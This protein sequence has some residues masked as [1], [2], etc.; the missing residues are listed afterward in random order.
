[1]WGVVAAGWAFRGPWA[2]VCPVAAEEGYVEQPVRSRGP[3]AA[4]AQAGST[5]GRGLG[6]PSRLCLGL[7]PRS[8]DTAPHLG[9]A[10]PGGA[11]RGRPPLYLPPEFPRFNHAC[12]AVV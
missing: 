6:V 10:S 8:L 4:G 5:G 9:S 3:W 12:L 7:S 2:P 1:M 11:L